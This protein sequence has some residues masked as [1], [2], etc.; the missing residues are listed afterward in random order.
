MPTPLLRMKD[1][2]RQQEPQPQRHQTRLTIILS[3]AIREA[4]T[5]PSNSIEAPTRTTITQQ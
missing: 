1:H 2:H 5:I 3:G 4:V